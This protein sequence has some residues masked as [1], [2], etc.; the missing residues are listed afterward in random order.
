MGPSGAGG[1][2]VCEDP[3]GGP[4][5]GRVRASSPADVDRAVARA[6]RAQPEWAALAPTA[7][8][9]PLAALAARLRDRREELAELDARDTGNLLR[10]MRADVDMAADTLERFAGYA[11]V[12]TGSA[13][14]GGAERLHLVLREPFGVVGRIVA[15]NHPL[16]FAAS[17]LAAPL[18]AGNAV[19]LKP[20]EVA[21]RSAEVLAELCADLFPDGLVQVVQG[22]ADV[23]R[24]LV[25]HPD[26]RRLAFIGSVATGRTIAEAA[27]RVA[28]KTVTL[29]LGGKNPLVVC[30][31]VP[32]ERAAELAVR[33][34]NLGTAG[35][36]CG[37]T[38]RLLVHSSLHDAVVEAV[39]ERLRAVRVGD[40]L[41]PATGMGPLSSA[42]QHGR[43][44][45]AVARARDQGARVVTGGGRPP[46]PA[47][48]AGNWFA[49][50]VLD[51][52]GPDI[53]V[54][55]TEVFG[56]VLTVT[57]W[58]TPAEAVELANATGY[59]L[60]ASVLTDRTGDALALAR[61]IDAGYVWVN[62]VSVHWPGLPF[63]GHRD[64]GV[65]T[66]ESLDELTSYTQSKAVHLPVARVT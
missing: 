3:C 15:F 12:A 10:R 7:R 61:A 49:P 19:L 28:V 47:Y 43:V 51:G 31:D 1:W 14:D 57:P 45:A 22:T 65:G 60:A 23:G 11:T 40:P 64:S 54:F 9:A 53:D 63:G 32:P 30:D 41:D 6:R 50:T 16:L 58:R 42:A 29:E 56:P 34:L 48:A 25:A 4:P 26:V 38:S 13:V 36:S 20:S 24:A 39:V 66:E 33:G 8:A 5:L 62:D 18:L 17:R 52:V 46:G 37:S 21:P 55:R 2:L 27:A 35:Q 59:G 44:A